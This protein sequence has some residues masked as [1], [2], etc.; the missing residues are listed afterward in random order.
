MKRTSSASY[1]HRQSDLVMVIVLAS[2]A[3]AALVIGQYYNT[4]GTL[5]GISVA[6]FVA[7]GFGAFALASGSSTSMFT[8]AAAN[9][10]MVIL[11]IQ[12]GRGTLEFHFGIFVLLG[13]LLV[14]RDWR[15]IVAAAGAFAVHHVL[16]DRLQAAGFGTF[17]APEPGLLKIV[18]HAA[19]VVIQTGVEVVLALRLRKGEREAAEMTSLVQF[20]DRDGVLNLGAESVAVSTSVSV[21]LKGVIGSMARSLARIREATRT[22]EVATM[23]IASGNLNLNQRTEEQASALQQTAATMAQ[24]GSTVRSTADS[25]QQANQLAQGAAA[26]AVKGG[27]VVGEVVRTMQGISDSSRKIGDIVGVID[28]ITFQTNLLALNAAVEAARA[29][30]QGRGFAVV[31]GEVRTLAQRSAEQAKEIKALIGHN[32]QQVEQGAALVD[33]AGKTMDEIVGCVR[34]VS[35]IVS[36]I[37]SATVE[38]SNGIQQVVDA[39]GQIDQVTQQNAALVEESAAVTESMKQQTQN[40]V[41]AVAAFKLAEG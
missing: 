41:G 14:Y 26:V 29:G 24:L 1:A 39:V 2:S 28:S 7:V 13:L 6:M 19:Y 40:L 22:I 11:H 32:V 37:T 17:C 15:P 16:F 25:A 3:A 12:L 36:E 20:V 8:L 9:T 27:E 30:E 21:A 4:L 34:R 35:D 18:M 33:R 38:Q 5:T 10:A 23:E 31:A